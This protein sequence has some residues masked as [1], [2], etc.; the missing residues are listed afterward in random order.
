MTFRYI[1]LATKWLRI[2]SLPPNDKIRIHLVA[3][4][5]S[6]RINR[7]AALLGLCSLRIAKHSTYTR[8]CNSLASSTTILCAL[9]TYSTLR[10]VGIAQNVHTC[11]HMYIVAVIFFQCTCIVCTVRNLHPLYSSVFAK[12]SPYIV[13]RSS[14]EFKELAN[15]SKKK[16]TRVHLFV[17]VETVK[18]QLRG[19]QRHTG[20]FIFFPSSVVVLCAFEFLA[21][22]S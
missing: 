17:R 9:C 11:I 4:R 14:M 2:L 15:R 3:K 18:A 8:T 20:R 1:G 10:S 22:V 16:K 21:T 7:L 6:K 13:S 5:S 12:S 19:W